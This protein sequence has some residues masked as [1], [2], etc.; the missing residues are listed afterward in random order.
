MI[1]DLLVKPNLPTVT[2]NRHI[3]GDVWHI[4]VPHLKCLLSVSD[5]QPACFNPQSHKVTYTHSHT[6]IQPHIHNR[7]QT[8]STDVGKQI[9]KKSSTCRQ[10]RAAGCRQC[11]KQSRDIQIHL[12]FKQRQKTQ[13]IKELVGRASKE[14]GAGQHVPMEASASRGSFYMIEHSPDSHVSPLGSAYSTSGY[15]CICAC[16]CLLRNIPS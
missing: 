5:S 1:K 9:Y 10:A 3:Q 7:D 4:Q 6:Y 14:P 15:V 13:E 11:H 8:R 12:I 2:A 16:V